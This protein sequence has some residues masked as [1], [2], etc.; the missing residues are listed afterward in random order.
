[1]GKAE[2]IKNYYKKKHVQ[3]QNKLIAAQKKRQRY[4]SQ[5]LRIWENL[6]S[7]IST[8][9]PQE[10]RSHSIKKLIG[11]DAHSLVKHLIEQFQE[12]M[13]LDNYPDWEPDHIKAVALWDLTIESE[14][15]ECFN[16]ENLQPLWKSDNRSK[17]KR[18]Q[19]AERSEVFS[20]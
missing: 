4:L 8:E 19:L 15:L 16:Y 12:D 11:C 1:M 20:K 5:E 10:Q 2:N 13:T 7:R 18:M 14:Q 6:V 9:I 3:E 17:G